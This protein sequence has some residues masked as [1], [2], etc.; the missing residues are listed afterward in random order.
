MTDEAI[1]AFAELLRP[2]PRP[3]QVA[4]Q[5]AALSDE[6]LK[7]MWDDPSGDWCDDVW[8]ELNRRGLGD[9]CTV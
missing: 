5:I 4:P 3:F 1:R 7:V 9:Y 6:Q 8:H 2:R